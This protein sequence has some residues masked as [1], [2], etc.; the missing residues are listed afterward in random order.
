MIVSKA[1]FEFNAEI[2]ADKQLTEA[3]ENILQIMIDF[4]YQEAALLLDEFRVH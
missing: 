2:K 3:Y 1:Y 4:N